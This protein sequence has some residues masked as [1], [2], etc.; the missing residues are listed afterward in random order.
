MPRTRLDR[1]KNEALCVLVNGYVRMNH[2]TVKEAAEYMRRDYRTLCRRLEKP[3][4]FS[5]DELL[6][7][8]RKMHIPIDE[9][10]AAIRY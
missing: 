2:G 7:L 4:S 1:N 6:D 9:L 3:G 8:G 5:I 10:R